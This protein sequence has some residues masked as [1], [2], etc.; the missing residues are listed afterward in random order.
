MYKY[1]LL[2]TCAASLSLFPACDPEADEAEFGVG[3]FDDEVAMRCGLN[4]YFD[5]SGPIITQ[6]GTPSTWA[7]MGK[8]SPSTSY[9]SASCG[10]Y[11]VVQAT[12][13]QNAPGSH[14]TVYPFRIGAELS[15]SQCPWTVVY[16]D[17]SIYHHG[18]W[19]QRAASYDTGSWDGTHCRIGELVPVYDP[20][21]EA[22]KVQVAA[23]AIFLDGTG[24]HYARVGVEVYKSVDPFD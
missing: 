22:E 21:D 10:D 11:Y 23:K 1:L 7:Y 19:H 6:P 13:L 4:G 3:H 8:Y 2:S 9:G 17:I 20:N 15:A 16:Y 24:E 5:V 12:G 18:A 14:V